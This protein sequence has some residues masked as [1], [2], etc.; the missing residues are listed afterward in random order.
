MGGFDCEI[1]KKKGKNYQK[2]NQKNP[3]S[4]SCNLV[5][6]MPAKTGEKM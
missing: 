5:N 2:K 6:V 4:E 3:K 1:D